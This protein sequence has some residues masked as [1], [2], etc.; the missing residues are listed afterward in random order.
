[1]TSLSLDKLVRR[2]SFVLQDESHVHQHEGDIW[3]RLVVYWYG[4][5]R[6]MYDLKPRTI[7]GTAV[8]PVHAI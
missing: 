5:I 4:F 1:M 6:R 3:L 7:P 8:R 2:K